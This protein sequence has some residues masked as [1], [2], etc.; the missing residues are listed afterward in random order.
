VALLR[1]RGLVQDVTSEELEKARSRCA[2]P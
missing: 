1:S 2:A